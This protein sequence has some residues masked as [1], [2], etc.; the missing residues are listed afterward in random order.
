MPNYTF[1]ID[2]DNFRDELELVDDAAAW[3][4]I[5]RVCGEILKDADGKLPPHS[6][7]MLKVSEGER[8]VADIRICAN[9]HAKFPQS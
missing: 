6:D 7:I 4:E 1:S 8:E 9:R 3:S 2:P 5:V